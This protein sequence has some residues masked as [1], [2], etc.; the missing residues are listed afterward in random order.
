MPYSRSS[1]SSTLKSHGIKKSFC[2]SLLYATNWNNP[3]DV[4]SFIKSLAIWASLA[5]GSCVCLTRA[6]DE[7]T[8][9]LMP[10]TVAKYILLYIGAAIKLP[11]TH[12][13]I[14]NTLLHTHHTHH[15]FPI[16]FVF[17]LLDPPP[18]HVPH[19]RFLAPQKEGE[20][21][22]YPYSS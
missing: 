5:V 14:Y 20:D 4:F 7:M 3:D 8:I 19:S 10:F 17:L 16:V 12:I 18:P 9:W 13:A 15:W 6:S 22:S 1:S 21:K 2:E 11:C